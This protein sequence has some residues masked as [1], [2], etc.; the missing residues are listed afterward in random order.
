MLFSCVL[1]FWWFYSA[2][3]TI[4]LLLCFFFRF[5]V[6]IIFLSL[7]DLV[8]LSSFYFILIISPLLAGFCFCSSIFSL[9]STL[10]AFYVRYILSV[11]WVLV[12][13]VLLISYSIYFY[14][15]IVNLSTLTGKHFGITPVVFKCA[16]KICDLNWLDKYEDTQH[17]TYTKS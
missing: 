10:I 17:V 3:L 1:L 7:L 2:L 16:I 15:F 13:L 12:F 4:F 14:F 5:F 8:C 6:T 11:W 9:F